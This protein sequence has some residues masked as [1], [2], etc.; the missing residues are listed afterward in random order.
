MI[1][2]RSKII[3]IPEN[4][5]GKVYTFSVHSFL[6]HVFFFVIFLCIV[7][8]PILETG[9][10]NILEKNNDLENKRAALH[11]E[12]TSLHYLKVRLS[13]IEEKEKGLQEYFG[14]EGNQSL[15][16][17]VGS[18]GTFG[19]DVSS[20]EKKERDSESKRY[21]R[22]ISSKQTLSE[23]L[24]T[25]SSNY[26][27]LNRLSAQKEENWRITPNIIPL[28]Y[29]NPRISSRFGWRKN[30]MTGKNEFHAGIDILGPK[31]THIIAPADGMVIT[32]GYDRWL[33]NYVVLQHNDEIK[34][35]YGHLKKIMVQDDMTVQRND[36]I[37]IMGN[38]GMSTSLHLH[39]A[40]LIND[41]P[42]NPMQYI[43]DVKG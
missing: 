8:V 9:L 42:V 4:G 43:L 10:F 21:K 5:S 36:V 19:P 31:D 20:F 26:D 41:R 40:V 14:M 23:K 34:T 25:L 15:A 32:L 6:L 37:G 39:Y 13:S 12:N 35:I 38:T 33:G 29:Q 11:E 16:Q 27:I 3:W 17:I 7:A 22:L 1:Q 18:G 28:D 2:A 30:P 24:Q